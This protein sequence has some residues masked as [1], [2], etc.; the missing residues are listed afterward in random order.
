[1]SSENGEAD[2]SWAVKLRSLT[3]SLT[4]ERTAYSSEAG[5]RA[6]GGGAVRVG[7]QATLSE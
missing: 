4:T 1:M 7:E 6:V 5:L 2:D 3:V